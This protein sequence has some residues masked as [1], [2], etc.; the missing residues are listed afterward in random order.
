MNN[1]IPTT[2]D[3]HDSPSNMGAV[4][5]RPE[6]V[7]VDSGLPENFVTPTKIGWPPS[8]SGESIDATPLTS[9]SA[10]PLVIGL[11]LVA[12][13]LAALAGYGLMQGNELKES[14]DKADSTLVVVEKGS[15]ALNS[16]LEKTMKNL[17]YTREEYEGAISKKDEEISEAKAKA[18]EAAD[19]LAKQEEKTKELL[20]KM[21]TRNIELE[22]LLSKKYS[23]EDSDYSKILA[24]KQALESRE[25]DLLAQVDQL[26]NT[27]PPDAPKAVPI[28]ESGQIEP[29]IAADKTRYRVMGLADGDSLNVRSGPGATY[30]TVI[31]LYNG[32]EL[33]ITGDAIMNDKDLW[34][35]CLVD[36]KSI[37]P[38][39]GEM[40]IL[41]RKGWVNS[42]YVE[43]VT[44]P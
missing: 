1:K 9:S 26:K 22:N 41:K 37:D 18:N 3:S 17:A 7:S 10:K 42:Y 16:D 40:G 4:P 25:K 28:T 15:K 21:V 27:S 12:V 33:S 44:I 2:S 34:L 13:G 35:P 5:L 24:E 31:R 8:L 23:K 38:F 19:E 36:E 30:L 43:R 6:P 29:V 39:I 11:S 20:E 14:L 32:V